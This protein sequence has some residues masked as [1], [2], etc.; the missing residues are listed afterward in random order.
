MSEINIPTLSWWWSNLFVGLYR[1]SHRTGLIDLRLKLINKSIFTWYAPGPCEAEIAYFFRF[2]SFKI[3]IRQGIFDRMN[4]ETFTSVQGEILTGSII[5]KA[6]CW[7]G[8]P[9]RQCLSKSFNF[10]TTGISFIHVVWIVLWISET[11]FFF[12]YSTCTPYS[13]KRHFLTH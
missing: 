12:V 6:T 11:R 10:T 4:W 8:I 9:F 2:V 7:S 13:P 1:D 5:V 3:F